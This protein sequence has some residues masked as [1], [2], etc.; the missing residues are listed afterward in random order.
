MDLVDRFPQAKSFTKPPA[1]VEV[2]LKAVCLLLGKNP[3]PRM[4]IMIVF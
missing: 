3:M 4:K 2:V 1:L